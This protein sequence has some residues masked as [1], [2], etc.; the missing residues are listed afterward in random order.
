MVDAADES[1]HSRLLVLDD[2]ANQLRTLTRIFEAE[3]FDVVGCATGAEALEHL[4]GG[5]VGVA[6]VD[7]R[8]LDLSGSEL[9]GKLEPLSGNV[10]IIIHT[11]Y[12]SYESAKD[13]VNVGAFAYVEKGADPSELIHHVH[14]A[15]RVRLERYA[16]QLEDAVAERTSELHEANEELR[17]KEYLHRKSEE[18]GGVGSF[19]LNMCTGKQEWSDQ[20]FTLLGVQPGDVSP[21]YESFLGFVHPDDKDQLIALTQRTFAGE[22]NVEVRYR[23]VRN[24]GKERHIHTRAKIE[25]DENGTP[26]WVL[27]FTQ[28]ITEQIGAESQLRESEE[29]YRLVAENA[30]D[31]IWAGDL[32]LNWTYLSPSVETLR[33]YSVAE[34]MRHTLDEIFTP[35]SAALARK[36]LAQTLAL[37]KEAPDALTRPVGIEAE[38]KCKDGSTIWVEMNASFLLGDDGSPVGIIGVSR[39]ITKRRRAE[40]AYRTLVDNSLQGLVILQDGRAV[41]ANQALA[42]M[43]GCTIDE[44]LGMSREELKQHVHPDDQELVWGRHQE[45]IEGGVP[46]SRYEHRLLRKD[47]DMLWVEI[48]ASR[49]HVGGRPAIQIAFLDVTA[50]KRAEGVVREQ[51]DLA[52]ALSSTTDFTEGLRQSIRTAMRVSNMDCG[53]VRLVDERT[54]AL[55]VACSEGVSKELMQSVSHFDSESDRARLVMAGEPLYAR[56]DD[57]P[58]ALSQ[59]EKREGVCAIAILPIKHEGR[60]IGCLTV[61]S[62]ALSE[63]PPHAQ[64]AL[65]AVAAQIG[66]SLA[67]LKAEE[68]LMR[69]ANE[70]CTTFDST[71]DAIMLLDT[72]NRVLRANRA[73]AE[74]AGVPVD[75]LVGRKY[76]EV[77]HGMEA[78]PDFCPYTELKATKRRV[79]L[80]TQLANGTRWVA[81]TMDPVF[82]EAENLVGAVHAACDISERKRVEKALTHSEKELS[83]VYDSA[84]VIIIVVD[85]DRRVRRANRAA[86]RAHSG[87]DVDVVGLRGG[88][89]LRCVHTLE[90]PEGCGF[91]PACES[92]GIRNL[93]IDTLKTGNSHFR[94]EH[95]V[96]VDYNGAAATRDALVSSVQLPL[97]DEPRALVMIEDI[98][99][100]KRMEAGIR[101]RDAELA[102]MA[103]LHTMGQLAAGLSHELNQPLYAITN[104][105]TGVIWRMRTGTDDP[106]ELSETMEKIVSQARRA[107]DIIGGLRRAVKKRDACMSSTDLN[108]LLCDLLK[109]VDHQIRQNSIA[110]RLDLQRDLPSVVADDIQIQQ[111]ALNLI[112]NALDAM[113][114]VPPE[115]RCLTLT[116][117]VAENGMVQVGVGDAGRGLS[118]EARSK[119][120]D[121]FFT[122]KAEGL[123]MGLAISQAIV[124]AHRG[125][126]W[127]TPNSPQGTIFC[128]SIPITWQGL[129][130]AN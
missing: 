46:P 48:I 118:D 67:R 120:F 62:H 36:T 32:D 130:R 31:V 15:F 86:R 29:R 74:F 90:H 100:Q 98:T 20:I 61:G 16:A 111:V 12:S 59:T 55:D 51:R 66:S 106:G 11:A 84:P 97:G 103:R 28:D 109:L 116:T 23:I 24:D 113:R 107:A 105:A 127:T 44:L 26:S 52:V 124:D 126:V 95:Q 89:V 13:A 80:E 54:G 88:E 110:V 8:L 77:V 129:D 50:R 56:L 115:Q 104:Y 41:F 125:R 14:R 72:E 114:D 38:A 42:G 81:I 70:W 6:V 45:R 35:A 22:K 85:E 5:D 57:L 82:D 76:H 19:R 121:P 18:I 60:V 102:H 112:R 123:G 40:E 27:G 73:A 69:A 128:F 108:E 58:L 68:A 79:Q 99:E 53:A 4:A 87:D 34:A 2:E 7:L 39:D 83:V 10:R 119:L 71:Q 117:S 33:G 93:V 1:R 78:P 9:L 101:Q 17:T 122:T 96:L 94:E 30:S 43:L 65:E 92:C 91:G 47:G 64:D 49:T 3:G 75:R 21:T 25:C 37:A 63:V